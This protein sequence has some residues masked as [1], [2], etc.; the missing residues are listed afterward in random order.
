LPPKSILDNFYSEETNKKKMRD[1]NRF[2]NSILENPLLRSNEVIEDF[3]TK[4]QEVFH[5]IKLKYKNYSKLV[6]LPDFRTLNGELDVTCYNN[7]LQPNYISQN[8]DNKRNILKEINTNLKK[9]I[10]CMDNLVYYVE[11]LSKLFFNLKNE[12]QYK[13]YNFEIF[14]TLGRYCK[15]FSYFCSDKKIILDEKV[16]E[17]LKYINSELKEM[18]NLCND[19]QYAKINLEKCE[20]VIINLEKGKSNNF[21]NDELY[22][23]E[24]QKKKFEKNLA[25]RTNN[26]LRNR[27]FEEYERIIEAHYFRTAKYFD[28]LSKEIKDLIGKEYSNSIRILDC[29]DFS[30]NNFNIEN[31]KNS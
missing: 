13:Q 29:L 9:V 30:K 28:K 21:K 15:N 19:S 25:Q 27:T 10:S 17:F 7:K 6:N 4:N 3:L 31:N 16:R 5:F 26:F 20:N 8:I 24:L 1:F 22:N 2:F 18:K 12:Y 23:Y 11:N 14:D